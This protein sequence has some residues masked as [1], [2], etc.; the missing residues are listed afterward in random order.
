VT[1]E[2][3]VPGAFT[4]E[5]VES[6]EVTTVAVGDDGRGWYRSD[7]VEAVLGP[8]DAVV[9]LGE[10]AWERTS[11]A[12][13]A[14]LIRMPVSGRLAALWWALSGVPQAEAAEVR[15][16]DGGRIVVAAGSGEA[17]TR[18]VTV[19]VDGSRAVRLEE[20][21]RVVRIRY[22]AE[23]PSP[24]A[25][26][27]DDVAKRAGAEQLVAWAGVLH[28]KASSINA[29]T[30]SRD[31]LRKAL[32]PGPSGI[33]V[34]VEAAGGGVAVWDGKRSV[35]GW[36][37]AL[38]RPAY[39]ELRGFG[40]VVCVR[41]SADGSV[42]RGDVDGGETTAVSPAWAV[43]RSGCAGRARLEPAGAVW[44]VDGELGSWQ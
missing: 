28:A 37:A 19:T 25:V 13:A 5:I 9:R 8:D 27:G 42:A 44:R 34:L 1:F 43:W 29:D 31:V 2:A 26:G 38:E 15:E 35:D 6:G 23:V 14:A 10:G 21:G 33:G 3:A 4:L 32:Q 11:R 20:A 24:T 22:E 36:A 12:G 16:A 39:V 18:F 40:A 41:L 17:G 7:E 30:R